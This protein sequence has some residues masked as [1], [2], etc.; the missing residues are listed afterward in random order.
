MPNL[1]ITAKIAGDGC[2]GRD[3]PERWA[4]SDP[5]WTALRGNLPGPGD[6]LSAVGELPSHEGLV[7]VPTK[8]LGAPASGS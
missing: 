3:C 2:A 6:D 4:T 1:K 8:L 7:F 5:E